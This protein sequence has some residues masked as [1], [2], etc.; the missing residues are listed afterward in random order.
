MSFLNITD[1]LSHFPT[2]T[3]KK[4]VLDK[5]HNLLKAASGGYYLALNPEKLFSASRDSKIS[6][7][8]GQSKFL[9]VDGVGIQWAYKK[10]LN[11]KF[12]IITGVDLMID[13][14]SSLQNTDYQ[15][16]L[17]GSTEDVVHAAH[18]NLKKKF[19][20]I[21]ISFAISGFEKGRSQIQQAL[22]THQPH[23]V[24]V[25]LGSPEQE[26]WIYSY[27]EKFPS[28]LFTGV[29]GSL[30]V[31]AGKV[32]RAPQLVRQLRLEWL[33]RFLT[34]P[35]KRW[36]RMLTLWHFVLLILKSPRSD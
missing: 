1:L 3:N 16:G 32:S 4:E 15:V 9:F 11:R 30:D 13:V 33:Y 23:L 17:F 7:I 19:P 35:I 20:S 5:I 8:L 27:Y 10:L 6:T 34:Q 22:T 29:G 36:K 28:I 12:E 21:H 2:L 24:F 31:I 25:A 26:K 18:E 14:L